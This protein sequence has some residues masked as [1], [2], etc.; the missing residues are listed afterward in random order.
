M[1]L[2]QHQNLLVFPLPTIPQITASES[3]P[4]L[5]LLWSPKRILMV[6]MN[7]R[8]RIDI[9]LQRQVAASVVAVMLYIRRKISIGRYLSILSR[10]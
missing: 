9:Q 7:I 4:I 8:Y 6:V 1:I 2:I 3:I 5:C 10:R